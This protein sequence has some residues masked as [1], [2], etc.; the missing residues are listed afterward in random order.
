MKNDEK[1]L[2]KEKWAGAGIGY[3]VNAFQDGLQY[4]CKFLS[5]QVR[6]MF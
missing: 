2:D 5:T 3:S 4:T 1:L 6:S